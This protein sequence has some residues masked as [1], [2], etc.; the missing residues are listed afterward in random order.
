[1]RDGDEKGAIEALR[2]HLENSRKFF[3]EFISK[4][5]NGICPLDN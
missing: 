1:L 3:E 2:Q 5:G 4:D